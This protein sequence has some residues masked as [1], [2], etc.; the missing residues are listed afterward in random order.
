MPISA[1]DL[2][3][4]VGLVV[5]GP[6]SWGADVRCNAPGVYA[7]SLSADCE[8]NDGLLDVA[9]VSASLIQAWIDRVPRFR[10]NGRRPP[11][12]RNVAEFIQRFWLP[13]ESILYIGMTTRRLSQRLREFFRHILGDPRPHKGGKW[14]KTL[15]N[16]EQLYIVFA[17][18]PPGSPPA[19]KEHE[20]LESFCAQV[21]PSTLAKLHNPSLPIPFANLEFPPRVRKQICI[22]SDTL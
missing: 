8:H 17:E 14:L 1:A 13:D 21:S 12:A 16:L 3:A 11:D 6:T 7:V 9:P 15:A 5:K 2:F 10:F 4:Q 20:L 19:Q 22:G 18:C